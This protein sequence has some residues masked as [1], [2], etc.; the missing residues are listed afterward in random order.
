MFLFDKWSS[1]LLF[2]N[3]KLS[4]LRI[5]QPCFFIIITFRGATPKTYHRLSDFFQFWLIIIT[6]PM[7]DNLG[8]I[9]GVS[10]LSER[11]KLWGFWLVAVAI[12]VI[13]R[14]SNRLLFGWRG[15]KS[16]WSGC[17]VDAF[18][19]RLC[20]SEHVFAI[21]ICFTIY[22]IVHISNT[23]RYMCIFFIHHGLFNQLLFTQSSFLLQT[24]II[25][26]INN[27][28]PITIPHLT[29]SFSWNRP[30][31]WPESNIVVSYDKLRLSGRIIC[32][33]GSMDGFA[34]W[35]SLIILIIPSRV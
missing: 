34:E 18:S 2:N 6:T 28:Q 5:A 1:F 17:W 27:I 8:I 26:N 16:R 24:I 14:V 7:I 29:L 20:L 25:P 32:I 10:W 9:V 19:W 12:N 11:V 31:W 4:N 22:G 13:V 3:I 15:Y 23:A 21:I 30:W 33:V 35:N